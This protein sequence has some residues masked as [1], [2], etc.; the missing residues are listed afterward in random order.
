MGL[1]LG[2]GLGRGSERQR[3][4]VLAEAFD[5][6]ALA[7]CLAAEGDDLDAHRLLSGWKRR[8]RTLPLRHGSWRWWRSCAWELRLRLRLAVSA[9]NAELRRRGGVKLV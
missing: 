4:L 1:G 5:Q 2:L 8:P 6:A 3:H 9:R 7:D